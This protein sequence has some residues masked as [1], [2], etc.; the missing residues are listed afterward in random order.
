VLRNQDR[1]IYGG[2]ITLEMEC[3]LSDRVIFL[4]TA[5]ERV[6]WGTTTGQFHTQFGAG[7]KFIIN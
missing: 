1:F 3:Y 6:L 4:L 5:R 2:A 7:V